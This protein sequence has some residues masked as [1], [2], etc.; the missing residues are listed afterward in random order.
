MLVGDGAASR[1]DDDFA[2]LVLRGEVE[3]ALRRLLA[4]RVAAARLGLTVLVH[5]PFAVFPWTYAIDMTPQHRTSAACA[6]CFLWLATFR[7]KP[8]SARELGGSGGVLLG[9]GTGKPVPARAGKPGP[10]SALA[11]F[12]RLAVAG[13]RGAECL[14]TS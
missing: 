7:A 4:R 9:L 10:S 8:R 13:I 5:A 3:G 14:V 2:R 6:L 11:I 12:C 1:L